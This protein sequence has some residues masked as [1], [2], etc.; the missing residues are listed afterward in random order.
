MPEP[1]ELRYILELNR[2]AGGTGYFAPVPEG[3]P[4]FDAALAVLRRRPMDAFLHQFA[5][6]HLLALPRP[7]LEA[8][9][10]AAPAD[11]RVLLALVCE[12]AALTGA[13]APQ[14]RFAPSALRE[15]EAA[16]PLIVLRHGRLPDR[17]L[18]ATWITRLA[19]NLLHHRP[20]PLPGDPGLPPLP[21]LPADALPATPV[22]LERIPVVRVPDAPAP[23]PPA[24]TIRTATE[25]LAAVGAL[26]SAEMRHEASLSPVALLR[27]WR[28]ERRVDSGPLRHRLGGFQTAYGRGLTLERARAGYLMEI[29][30]RYSAF[31]DFGPDAVLGHRGH[32]SLVRARLSEMRGAGRN[33]L[34]P[35]ELGLE[36]PYEDAPLFWRPA[37]AG[38]AAGVWVPAQ[39][40]YLFCNLD[41]AALFSALGSTGL[42][43]GNTPAEARLSAL[44]EV[45][46][47]DAE[48]VT[49]FREAGCFRVASDDPTLRPLLEDYRRHGVHVRFQDLTGPL[50]VPVYK[51]FVTAL[52]GTIVKGTGAHPDGRR[53]LVAALTET[54]HPYPGGPRSRPGPPGEAVRRVEDLP[55]RSGPSAEADLA[56]IEG[57]LRANGLQPVYADLTRRDLGLPV[58]RALVP[59]LETL[60]DFDRYS[61]LSPR[62]AAA[63]TARQTPECS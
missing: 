6:E 2:T 17:H 55:D 29:V 41:E 43:A 7:R 49:P 8:L 50:G 62:L 3:R 44:L 22:P 32:V 10:G 40:V 15:I 21:S 5:L 30:E 34:D 42:A 36:V 37:E 48:A 23:V 52:D 19:Q 54:M 20:L 33:A 11:D 35:N 51:C 24:D 31:A 4:G 45:I 14:E 38:G 27:Q 61:R 57:L 28:L 59:G 56:R 39:A 47:R 1:A 53:A 12:A 16:T 63:A 60:A 13:F 9:A 18:H 26:V 58:V 25:R 46:E